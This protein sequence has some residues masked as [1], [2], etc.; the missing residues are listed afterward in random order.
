VLCAGD[1]LNAY[2]L[3]TS[4]VLAGQMGTA[5]SGQVT[6]EAG[7]AATSSS[8]LPGEPER[9]PVAADVV[10]GEY[11]T[12]LSREDPPT[13]HAAGCTVVEDTVQSCS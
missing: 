11:L 3:L 8:L 2:L 10:S 13:L 12:F 1:G 6:T 9:P 4:F 7:P 5:A